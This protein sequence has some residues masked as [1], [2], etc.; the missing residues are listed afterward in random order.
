MRVGL[1]KRTE[2]WH[3]SSVHYYTGGLSATFR[4]KRTLAIDHVLLPTDA[5]VCPGVRTNADCCSLKEGN[6]I[7]ARSADDARRSS[8]PI[9]RTMHGRILLPCGYSTKQSD[10]CW[11]LA[12]STQRRNKASSHYTANIFLENAHSSKKYAY[13]KN[14][15]GVPIP[16]K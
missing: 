14:S 1:A 16:R 10:A 13:A 7:P 8:R 15:V 11:P 5:L 9:L 2:Q 12:A 3:R 6:R 4:P